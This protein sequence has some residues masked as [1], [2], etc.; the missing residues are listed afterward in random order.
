MTKVICDRCGK[1]MDYAQGEAVV[2]INRNNPASLRRYDLCTRCASVTMTWLL[3]KPA[4]G[5]QVV[6]AEAVAN[7]G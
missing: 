3:T 7:G 1:E 5:D 2:T 6:P 4:P